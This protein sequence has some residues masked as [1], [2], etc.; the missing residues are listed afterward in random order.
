[1]TGTA[2]QRLWKA[3][4]ALLVLAI[5]AGSLLPMPRLATA[6]GLDKLEHFLA[7]GALALLASGIV[8]PERLWISMARCFAL[9]VAVELL[10]GY[11]VT[12][13][14][15]DWADLVANALGV[16]AAWAAASGGRAGWARHVEAWLARRSRP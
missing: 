5:L 9:G 6:D 14:S 15:A 7:Y 4:I 10:Q 2:L 16:L 1:M 13:R 11:V 12:G 8:V 3:A